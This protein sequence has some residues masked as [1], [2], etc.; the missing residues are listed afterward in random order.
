MVQSCKVICTRSQSQ[1]LNSG[2]E[3]RIFIF[4]HYTRQLHYA[5][6]KNEIKKTH[7]KQGTRKTPLKENCSNYFHWTVVLYYTICLLQILETQA[8]EGACPGWY[9]LLIWREKTPI[10][11]AL[12]FYHF[13]TTSKVVCQC[14]GN[15]FLGGY[16]IWVKGGRVERDGAVR[17]FVLVPSLASSKEPKGFR[18]ILGQASDLVWTKR[19][20][21]SKQQT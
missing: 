8:R 13:F 1:D 17:L 18:W 7:Y 9:R 14:H 21:Q 20:L 15:H 16:I 6:K 10:C 11:K 3:T 12:P 2:R 19:T 5:E 4:S